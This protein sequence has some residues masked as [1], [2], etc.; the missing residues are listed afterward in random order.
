MGIDLGRPFPLFLAQARR[1]PTV[2]A[3]ISA[4][5]GPFVL[6][7]EVGVPNGTSLTATSGLPAADATESYTLTHPVTGQTS[8]FSVSVWRR[9]RWTSTL[10]FT[11]PSGAH[12]LFDE[13]EFDVSNS[14][15]VVDMNDTNASQDP[16]DPLAIFRRCTFDGN[17]TCSGCLVGG[18]AWLTGCD[19]QHT[20]DGW[21]GWLW[22]GIV[23]CNIICTTDG[24]LDPHSD[25]V[26]VNGFGKSTAY[27]CWLDAG[28]NAAFANAAVRIGTEF[29]AVDNVKVYYCG[30]KTAGSSTLQC[31]GD[32]GSG[33]ITNVDFEHN[34][35]TRD[36]TSDPADFAETT[37]IT[38]VDNAFFDGE[39]ITP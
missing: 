32:S 19:L 31:R 35:W 20:E 4:P 36:G 26:Q 37:G 27:H 11:P 2:P 21:A 23:D 1:R 15:W 17:D 28:T 24:E 5:T 14:N 6:G 30:M 33:D 34:R 12:Y 16:M 22:G 38:W 13:C 7:V 8:T 18:N 25:C 10:S 9:R 39:V 29:S 3:T